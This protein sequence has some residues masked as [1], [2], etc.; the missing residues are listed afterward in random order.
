MDAISFIGF[1]LLCFAV[2]CV[3]LLSIVAGSKISYLES[4]NKELREDVDRL[5]TKLGHFGQLVG[6]VEEEMVEKAKRLVEGVE[7]D[8]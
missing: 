8:I 3:W 4:E 5:M 7:V 1:S 2:F 6:P